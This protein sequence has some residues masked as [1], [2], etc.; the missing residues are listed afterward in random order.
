MVFKIGVAIKKKKV[1]TE[2]AQIKISKIFEMYQKM[3]IDIPPVCKK[4]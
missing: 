1:F 4:K 3:C 2:N